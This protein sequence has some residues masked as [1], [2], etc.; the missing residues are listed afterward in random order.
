MPGH[1]H[2]AGS[3]KQKNK[4][5]GSGHSSKRSLKR[6]QGGKVNAVAPTSTG[7]PASTTI[8][9]MN[10]GMK[11]K[12]LQ[13]TKQM[14]KEK[15]TQDYL[16]RRTGTNL[17][18]PIVI[19]LMPMGEQADE[20]TL[21]NEILNAADRVS[22]LSINKNELNGGSFV[23]AFESI[24]TRIH[25]ISIARSFG[26]FELLDAAKSADIVVPIFSAK[27][28]SDNAVSAQGMER[29]AL[30]RA[31]GMPA[32]VGCLQHTTTLS[33]KVAGEFKRMVFSLF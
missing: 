33:I 17:G 4:A 30:L 27:D 8:N 19:L 14:R 26:N 10:T 6:A 25:V 29:V 32:I 31:H 9:G 5:H 12:R 22:F 3:L 28:G 16:E 20:V 23:A 13:Q 21:A 7:N 15:K 18:A 24:K 1:R 2:N 11:L